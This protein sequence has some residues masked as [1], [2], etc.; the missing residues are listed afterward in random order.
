MSIYERAVSYSYGD[1]VTGVWLCVLYVHVCVCVFKTVGFNSS[2]LEWKEKKK[3]T[4]M[5]H[6]NSEKKIICIMLILTSSSAYM[7]DSVTEFIGLWLM[8]CKCHSLV[9]LSLTSHILY[10]KIIKASYGLFLYSHPYLHMYI[11][12]HVLF[13]KSDSYIPIYSLSPGPKWQLQP[14]TAIGMQC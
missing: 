9:Q 13:Y 5:L 8:D 7:H 2:W 14:L 3:N 6:S 4:E 11:N 12:L 10:A 1:C